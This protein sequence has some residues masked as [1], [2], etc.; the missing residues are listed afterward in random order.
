MSCITGVCW[1]FH[2][3]LL[4]VFLM[5]CRAIVLIADSSGA[6]QTC[7]RNVVL[8][9]FLFKQK[10]TDAFSRFR[11]DVFMCSILSVIFCIIYAFAVFSAASFCMPNAIFTHF[12]SSSSLTQAYCWCVLQRKFTC[13]YAVL[14]KCDS[15]AMC[16]LVWNS[17]VCASVCVNPVLISVN[18]SVTQPAKILYI[19]PKV[20]MCT[21][22]CKPKGTM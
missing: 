21:I 18:S 9:D 12:L 10:R 14:G 1:E 7:D 15:D 2:C 8:V 5:N 3:Y 17:F 20:S 4:H 16:V 22:N 19:L 11:N 13:F 6:F